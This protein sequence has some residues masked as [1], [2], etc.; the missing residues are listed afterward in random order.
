ML[1][2]WW[3]SFLFYVLEITSE[4]S[5]HKKDNVN[6]DWQ[7]WRLPIINWRA[8]GCTL[9]TEEATRLHTR[10]RHI[11]QGTEV[12]RHEVFLFCK[13]AQDSEKSFVCNTIRGGLSFSVA[14]PLEIH[15]ILRLEQLCKNSIFLAQS[16]RCW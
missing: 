9:R 6:E 10:H 7:N 5:G 14:L 16:Y 4:R 13:G 12:Y 3:D 1:F 2:F 15:R 11:F 8:T